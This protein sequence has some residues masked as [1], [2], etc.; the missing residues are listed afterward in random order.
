M[1]HIRTPSPVY[2]MF[3][4]YILILWRES[5]NLPDSFNSVTAYTWYA[6]NITEKVKTCENCS[7]AGFELITTWKD[8]I[9]L[10]ILNCLVKSEYEGNWLSLK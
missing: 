4:V 3:N 5:G 1:F 2:V 6:T 7:S 9:L 10:W 8:I